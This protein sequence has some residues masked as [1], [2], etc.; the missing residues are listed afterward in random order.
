MT[1]AAPKR[2]ARR[3][4]SGSDFPAPAFRPVQLATLIDS[5]PTGNRWLHE[6]KY[7]GYR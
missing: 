3:E 2:S 4:K 7:D 1:K 5:V 6:M